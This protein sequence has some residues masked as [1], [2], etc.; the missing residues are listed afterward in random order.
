MVVDKETVASALRA[1][2]DHDRAAQ[3]QSSLPRSVDTELE[4]GTIHQLGLNVADVEAVASADDD[5]H[6]EDHPLA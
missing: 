5:R 2:G 4:A 1:R 3:A 6:A